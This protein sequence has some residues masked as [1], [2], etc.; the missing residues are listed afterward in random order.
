MNQLDR[1][2]DKFL[3]LKLGTRLGIAYKILAGETDNKHY[4]LYENPIA[5]VTSNVIQHN[6]LIV[7][8]NGIR[9]GYV[10]VIQE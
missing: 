10:H 3:D 6:R 7:T 5:I 8:F 4:R 9:I 1:L 2:A